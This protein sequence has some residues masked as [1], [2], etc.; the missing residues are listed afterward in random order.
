MA[1]H[2]NIHKQLHLWLDYIEKAQSRPH[3]LAESIGERKRESCLFVPRACALLHFPPLFSATHTRPLIIKGGTRPIGRSLSL[4]RDRRRAQWR[5]TA[6]LSAGIIN[7]ALNGSL[8]AR[9]QHTPQ[10]RP[11]LSGRGPREIQQSTFIKAQEREPN[12]REIICA[13]EREREQSRAR[14]EKSGGRPSELCGLERATSCEPRRET[15][16]SFCANAFRSFCCF[17]LHFFPFMGTP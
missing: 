8:G 11:R 3:A 10:R 17:F 16:F 5:R 15:S 14:P 13:Y 4:S 1:P 9:A 2:K 7:H 6:A 12:G